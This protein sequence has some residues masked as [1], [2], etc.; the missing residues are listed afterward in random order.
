MNK[1]FWLA[2]LPANKASTEASIANMNSA[3]N[4]ALTLV[5]GFAAFVAQALLSNQ[6]ALTREIGLVLLAM[7]GLAILMTTHFAVRAAKSYLNVVRFSLVERVMISALASGHPSSQTGMSSVEDTYCQYVRDWKSPLPR[8]VVFRKVMFELG[9]FWLLLMLAFV[10]F[11]VWKSIPA[12]KMGLEILALLA[13]F[14]GI[15]IEL[16]IFRQS[17]YLRSVL[18]EPSAV[19][20]K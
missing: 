14:V 20:L 4:W 10:Y 7:T 1:E 6:K 19:R 8:I 13:T 17:A 11:S 18:P 5:I 2:Y 15:F 9:F 12:D 16:L 3:I